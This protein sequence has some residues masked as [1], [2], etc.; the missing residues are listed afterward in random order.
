MFH[1][2]QYRLT[3]SA[4]KYGARL[5]CQRSRGTAPYTASKEVRNLS[6]FGVYRCNY[7]YKKR[8]RT[9]YRF[10]TKRLPST[11]A[12]T[13]HSPT[14]IVPSDSMY[15]T[16]SGTT[17]HSTDHATASQGGQTTQA[18]S[19]SSPAQPWRVHIDFVSLCKVERDT[20]ANA[21]VGPCKAP[22]LLPRVFLLNH[23]DT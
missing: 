19:A 14:P 18:C 5:T 6:V 13:A 16:S 15:G 2:G 8:G 11:M 20:S 1:R 12:Y 4:I 21:P 23:T 7:Q 10:R 3:Q 22:R 9:C 17:F